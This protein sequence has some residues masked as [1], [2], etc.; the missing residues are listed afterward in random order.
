MARGVIG[1]IVSAALLDNRWVMLNALALLVGWGSSR[2][3][4]L[5]DTECEAAEELWL[6][7][8]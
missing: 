1:P 4:K 3:E 6:S 2:V 8:G 5:P 7:C